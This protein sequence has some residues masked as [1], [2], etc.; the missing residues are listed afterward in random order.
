MAIQS[1]LLRCLRLDCSSSFD[2]S[3]HRGLISVQGMLVKSRLKIACCQK[4][5]KRT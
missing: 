2:K 4:N 5:A 1:F 3:A